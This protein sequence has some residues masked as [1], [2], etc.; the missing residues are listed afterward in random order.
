M[1]AARATAFVESR[2]VYGRGLGGR[3]GFNW[4]TKADPAALD[5]VPLVERR[6][7]TGSTKALPVALLN[8]SGA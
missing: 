2:V 1:S 5:S 3:I 4:G 8:A 6:T 7:G